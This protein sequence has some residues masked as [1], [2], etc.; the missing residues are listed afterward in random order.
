MPC[1][2]AA[3]AVLKSIPAG[4][5]TN[6]QAGTDGVFGVGTARHRIGHAIAGLDA[7]DVRADRFD[8]SR[9]LASQHHRRRRRIETRAEISVDEIHAR[10]G[11]LDHCLTRSRG[12][13]RYVGVF[14]FF[15]TTDFFDKDGFHGVRTFLRRW[16]VKAYRI[17][18]S[19]VK[20]NNT[21]R[22]SVS[23]AP[24]PVSPARNRMKWRI[25]ARCPRSS[26]K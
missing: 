12:G 23:M 7:G 8:H 17:R 22:A 20:G 26:Q 1:S 15:G 25:V 4:S 3:A 10:C 9:A 5:F 24:E 13:F 2:I 16:T 19:S 14:Q 6:C 18:Y 21:S 11:D